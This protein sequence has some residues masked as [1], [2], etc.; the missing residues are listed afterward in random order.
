MRDADGMPHRFAS[1][2]EPGRP[3]TSGGRV[4]PAEGAHPHLL[5]HAGHPCASWLYAFTQRLGLTEFAEEAGAASEAVAVHGALAQL[6]VDGIVQVLIGVGGTPRR[7]GVTC[8]T[9][10]WC[11]VP[12]PLAP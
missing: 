6:V 1:C 9:G 12:V 7:T 10:E 8:L 11:L 4:S 5:A 3:L 2:P